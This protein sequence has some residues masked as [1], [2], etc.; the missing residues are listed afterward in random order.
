MLALT[1]TGFAADPQAVTAILGINPTSTGRKGEP[2]RSGRVRTFNGWWFE[3]TPKRLCDG[4]EH[5]AALSSILQ[6]LRGRE[7]NFAK[8]RKQVAPTEVTIY[9]G[10]YVS[11]RKRNDRAEN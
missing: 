9:G 2:A 6:Q 10:L 11:S 1:I 7:Q 3:A 8:L 4:A 5:A